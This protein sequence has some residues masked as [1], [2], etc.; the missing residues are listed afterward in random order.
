MR[1][2]QGGSQRAQQQ[3]VQPSRPV[4]PQRVACRGDV[5]AFPRRP[6]CGRPG[7]AR[8]LRR[9]PAGR[10]GRCARGQRHAGDRGQ[11]TPAPAAAPEKPVAEKSVTRKA[12]PD[13]PAASE[14]TPGP[15][16]QVKGC[17]RRRT[18]PAR[19]GEARR[20]QR[21]EGRAPGAGRRGG[22]DDSVARCRVD[23]RQEHGGVAGGADGDQRARRSGEAAGRQ[24]PGDQQSAAADARRQDLLHPPHRVSRSCGRWPSS[25]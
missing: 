17:A 15:N 4:R 6:Y 1:S 7:V 14:V 21:L 3:Y 22:H 18:R 2:D 9:L 10:R 25:R 12:A 11:R 20:G 8:L 13:K 23:G 19:A 5:P 24:P 16:A